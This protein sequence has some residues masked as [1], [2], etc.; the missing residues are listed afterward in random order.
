MA[1]G[2]AEHLAAA[3]KEIRPEELALTSNLGLRRSHLILAWK[4]RAVVVQFRDGFVILV[5]L[6]VHEGF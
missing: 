4:F 3:R 5:K 2:C 1:H 6:G